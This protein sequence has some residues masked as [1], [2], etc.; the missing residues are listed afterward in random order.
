MALAHLEAWD[1]K[2]SKEKKE[3]VVTQANRELLVLEEQ[4]VMMVQRD[5]LGLKV[6]LVNLELLDLQDLQ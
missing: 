1:P 4:E 5:M 3:I 2:E 6:L